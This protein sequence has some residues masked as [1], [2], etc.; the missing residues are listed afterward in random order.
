MLPADNAWHSTVAGLPVHTKSAT[1]VGSMGAG[2][3][4]HADFGAGKW[5]GGPF[6]IPFLVVPGTQAG[7]TVKFQYKPESDPGPYPIPPN[8]PIEGGP[9]SR[10]DRH[11]LI[12]DKD[13][14]RLYELF[15][16][17][18]QIDGTWKAGSGAIYDMRSNTLRPSGW[19]SADAAGL[20]I[21]PG[22]VRY[23]E[24]AAGHIDH[25]IRMTAD[26]TQN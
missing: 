26:A 20:A 15:A 22:L 3:G 24:V 17:Y 21:L 14:C 4:M 18:P 2:T 6:G 12:V 16:A 13:N 5:D 11:I 1:Y 19:T 10:G 25:A 7:V 8:V 9:R 23:D